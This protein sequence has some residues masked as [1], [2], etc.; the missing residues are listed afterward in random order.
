M[1]IE[2]SQIGVLNIPTN[3][4]QR[5]TFRTPLADSIPEVNSWIVGGDF[6][7]LDLEDQEGRGPEFV[8]IAQAE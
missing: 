8:G 6:N 2:G 5:A 4:Q 1:D 3:M 7:N